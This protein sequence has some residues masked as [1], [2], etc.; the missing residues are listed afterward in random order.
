MDGLTPKLP[1]GYDSAGGYI[2]I[3]NYKDLVRQNFKMLV[4]TI[5]GERV[6]MP[7]FGVGLKKYLFEANT[8][9]TRS[10]ISSK[11]YE[12]VRT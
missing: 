12:Q 4:L 3:D 10:N 6:M 11:I 5:P 7:E 1:L 2:N 8:Q 9:K